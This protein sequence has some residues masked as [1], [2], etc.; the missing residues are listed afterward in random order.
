MH[1]GCCVSSL[2]LP[3]PFPLPLLPSFFQR[4]NAFPSLY[5]NC[6]VRASHMSLRSTRVVSPWVSL[7]NVVLGERPESLP[8]MQCILPP[9]SL[10]VSMSVDPPEMPRVFPPRISCPPGELW[11]CGS[12]VRGAGAFRSAKRLCPRVPG[13]AR[14]VLLPPRT[15]S[16][17]V[18]AFAST[19]CAPPYT[20]RL[21]PQVPAS[22]RC[23]P[24]P[25]TERLCLRLCGSTVPMCY[26][27]NADDLCQGS[28][29]FVIG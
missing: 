27:Q 29:G 23:V 18:P 2:G 5:S 28:F 20:E 9:R 12:P 26:S 10:Q 24:P 16:A 7:R 17:C 8:G 21:C 1:P 11:V 13:S 4:E 19:R 6:G 15:R 14:C 22:T 25:Y 3:R